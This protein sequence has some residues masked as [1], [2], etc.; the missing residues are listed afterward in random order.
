MSFKYSQ[1][2]FLPRNPEKYIGTGNIYYRSS[3]ELTFMRFCDN[4]PAVLHWASESVSIPYRN[5]LTGKSTV[6]V[7]DFLIVYIDRNQKKHAELIEIKPKNQ[8]L[9]ENVGK[10][11][12]NQ[13]QFIINEA[14]WEA[15]RI[16]CKDKGLSFRIINESDIFHMGQ[17]RTRKRQKGKK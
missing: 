6:Y 13:A 9:I 1:G 11:P 3:W 15:A 8:T 17:K 14:K 16:F 2:F 10:N 12:Y 7:P 5:P 4:N